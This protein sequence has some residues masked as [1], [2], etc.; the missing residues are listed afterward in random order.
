MRAN[1]E[2]RVSPGG[3]DLVKLF[4]DKPNLILLDETLEYLINAGGVK[5]LED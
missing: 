2:A 3:D 4:G 5:V 1:D